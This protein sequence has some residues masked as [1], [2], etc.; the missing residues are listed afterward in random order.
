MPPDSAP[1]SPPDAAP[2]DAAP[3]VTIDCSN[4]PAQAVSS[5]LLQDFIPTEDIAF[6]A[7][8]NVIESDTF[9]IYKTTRQGQRTTFVPNFEFRAG[10]RLTPEGDLIVN[11]DTN[12]ALVRVDPQGVRYTLLSGLSYPNGMEIDPDGW[13]YVTEQSAE[14]VLRVNPITGDYTVLVD[15]EISQ[16]NGI[17]FDETY[18][19]LYIGGFSGERTV[20][21]LEID[22]QGNTG[23]LIEW[24]TN[25][26]SGWLDGIAVDECGYVYIADYGNFGLTHIRRI[27]PVTRQSSVYLPINQTYMPNMQWGSGLGGWA[28]D[29]LYIV[30]VQ[31]GIWE[32][33][34]GGV[35]SKPRFWP[36]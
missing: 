33:D 3:V 36:E 20:Y 6:D 21:R 22:R 9:A 7:A 8:G 12:G 13:V 29:R 19:Y 35:R 26:G 11:D 28:D 5:T 24:A 1:P 15:G 2:P 27:D 34:M 30:A 25:V 32:V 23:E 4:L 31:E 14:R 17:A 18:S 16:P 10:M